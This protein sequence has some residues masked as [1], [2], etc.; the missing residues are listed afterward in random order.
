VV[1]ADKLSDSVGARAVFDAAGVGAAIADGVP[2]LAP[3]GTIVVVGIHETSFP[4]DPTTLLLQEAD[5]VGSLVYDI[6][7]PQR[8]HR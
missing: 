1:N 3:R 5:V 6:R 8:H 4:F 7:A 2:A